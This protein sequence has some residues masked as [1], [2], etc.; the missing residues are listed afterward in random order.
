MQ[1]AADEVNS[2]AKSDAYAKFK[3]GVKT[4]MSFSGKELFDFNPDLALDGDDED[5]AM[6]TYER[7]TKDDDLAV[8]EEFRGTDDAYV[9]RPDHDDSRKASGKGKENEATKVDENLFDD[10]ELEGLDD[11]DGDDDN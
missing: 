8:P 4:G 11:D 9:P 6:E 2:Q 10:E 3:S 7:D 5:G 1:E